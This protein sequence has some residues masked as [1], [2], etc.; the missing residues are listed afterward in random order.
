VIEWGEAEGR[1]HTVYSL[2]WLREHAYALDREDV[3]APDAEVSRCVLEAARFEGPGKLMRTA[4]DLVNEHGAAL[5]RGAGMDNEELTDAFSTSA[6]LRVVETRF[7][8]IDDLRTGDPGPRDTGG[9]DPMEAPVGLH[10]GQP[11][12][13]EPP[14]YQMLHCLRPADEGGDSILADAKQAALH[15]RSV[16]GTDFELLTKVPVVF[17]GRDEAF[18]ERLA[19][20]L[21]EFHGQEFRRVRSSYL[22]LAPH[23]IPFETLEP[24]YRAYAR[25][26]R[27][28]RDPRHQ[29]RFRLEA[30]DALLYDNFRMLHARTGFR[31]ERRVRG[32]CFER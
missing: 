9:P 10:T 15:L 18:D 11:F 5:M 6:G 1:H 22:T 23:R 29:L 25:F 2:G 8:C 7:R 30:G 26:T 31:G 17:H 20:P 3:P 16:D 32:I 24:W 28:V 14:H 21:V 4:L 13:A 27:L 12:L 19:S